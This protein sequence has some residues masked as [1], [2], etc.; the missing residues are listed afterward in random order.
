MENGPDT[1]LE[2]SALLLC[3]DAQF[4]GTIREVLTQFGVVPR[5]VPE[6]DAALPLLREYDF[7][8]IILDWRE[9][10]N[11]ADFLGEM[12]RSKLN[13]NAVLV[14]IVRDLLD[15]RQAFTA[16]VHFLIHKPASVT[17]IERCLRAASAVCLA[18]HR[19]LHRE[20]VNIAAS[21]T[22]HA[23]QFADLTV[24][25]LSETGARVRVG[26]AAGEPPV[27]T[28]GEEFE[29]R[30]ALPE[31]SD[32]LHC[33]AM[34]VWTSPEG[35]AGVRFSHFS[36]QQQLALERWVTSCIQ[37]SRAQHCQRLRAA[38]A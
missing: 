4:L 35:D 5:I 1:T 14:A 36:D 3:S 27:F 21:V 34:V 19:K 7:D 24:T 10:L 2:M 31:T 17:Q 33:A 12:R 18:R 29:L 26:L 9:I 8:V 6:G 15:L 25:N 37:R 28:A 20:P 38:C 23:R 13:R 16:G 22:S 30:F 32:L 11:P